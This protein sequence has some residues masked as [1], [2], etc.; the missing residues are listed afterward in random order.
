MIDHPDTIGGP[1]FDRDMIGPNGRLSRLHKGEEPKGPSANQKRLESEQL[2]MVRE[3]MK[4]L[5]RQRNLPTPEAPPGL[6]PLPPPITANSA[7]AAQ[8][9]ADARRRSLK[10]TAPARSTIFAGE[11]ASPLG[12]RKTILG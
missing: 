10:R 9:E 1:Y 4:E 12:G 5:E 6:A 11:S 3:Q 8:A 2:K 7:D